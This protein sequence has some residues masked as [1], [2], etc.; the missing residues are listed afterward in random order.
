MAITL[1]VKK[2]FTIDATNTLVTQK[3]FLN[4]GS[5]LDTLTNRLYNKEAKEIVE[6]P[7]LTNYVYYEITEKEYYNSEESDL[8]DTVNKLLFKVYRDN[9]TNNISS[10]ESVFD[11][12]VYID[13]DGYFNDIIVKDNINVT[14]DQNIIVLEANG[15]IINTSYFPK[16]VIS[17]SVSYTNLSGEK[18]SF[19]VMDL[20]NISKL[21]R[22][23]VKMN[24]NLFRAVSLTLNEEI[25][26][27]L[28]D[29]SYSY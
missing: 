6:V 21:G 10:I 28:V 12:D 9:I 22:N 19:G 5:I 2:P 1:F 7:F 25:Q 11:N 18:T 27:V 16:S 8:E 23:Y 15:N 13:F 26:N 20:E 24:M 29:V 14:T 17:I 4:G 3:L